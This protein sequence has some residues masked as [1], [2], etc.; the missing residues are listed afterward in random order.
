M[1]TKNPAAALIFVIEITTTTKEAQLHDCSMLK[2][3]SYVF[4]VCVFTLSRNE[5]MFEIIL[6]IKRACVY[7][8]RQRSFQ[9]I[10]KNNY[11]KLKLCSY[12]LKPFAQSKYVLFYFWCMYFY[13]AFRVMK[14]L[15][16]FA[17]E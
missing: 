5:N 9:C 6:G 4:K 10:I 11:F 8:F 2:Q 13:M 14:F 16:Y 17:S 15:V 3:T 12:F 7:T 1:N